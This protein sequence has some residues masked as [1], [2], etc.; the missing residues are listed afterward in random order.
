[1][2]KLH[3]K[4]QYDWTD[5]ERK[6]IFESRQTAYIF[7]ANDGGAEGYNY[8]Q[9]KYCGAMFR[10][11]A[12]SMRP[13]RSHKL[14]T[15]QNC[16]RLAREHEKKQKANQKTEAYIKYLQRCMFTKGPKGK[17]LRMAPCKVCGQLFVVWGSQ[18]EYCSAGCCNY[19]HMKRK[20]KYRDK[21]NLMVLYKRDKGICHLCG[22]PCDLNDY[23]ILDDGS[24]KVGNNYPS[25]DHIIP[26]SKG[27]EDTYQNIKLAHMK[28][29]SIKNDR[30]ILHL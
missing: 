12:Q 20:E 11:T 3:R 13:S 7:I 28:C 25:R 29:N 1:M 4:N 21:I 26:K 6:Q 17:Q 14:L 2:T 24:F 8:I 22:Q 5:D 30:F 16:E 19:K 23:V 18:T 10:R 27:G 9:C 15:C